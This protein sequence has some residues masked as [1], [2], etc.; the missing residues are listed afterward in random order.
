MTEYASI[1]VTGSRLIRTRAAVWDKLDEIYGKYQNLGLI[2]V[3]GNNRGGADMFANAWAN[4]RKREGWL[5]VPAPH[6]AD[7]TGPCITEPPAVWNGE[8]DGTCKH[9][10][11]K[12]RRGGSST[13][14][15]AGNRRNQ[16]MTDWVAAR[17]ASGA[18]AE[19]V[20]FFQDGAENRGTSD[21]RKRMRA[22]GIPVDS[23]SVPR[24]QDVAA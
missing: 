17:M 15:F 22:A 10:P 7:W 11:R 6:D 16:E 19:G 20:A 24:R 12:Y 23:V 8:G 5:V 2:I 9:G 13:C 1:L 18:P 14:P 21:C 3:H 4:V